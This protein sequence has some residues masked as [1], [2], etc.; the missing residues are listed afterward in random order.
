M[1]PGGGERHQGVPGADGAA[2]QDPL[3][4]HDPHDGPGDVVLPRG[5]EVRHL[6]RLP[7]QER[8]PVGA[9]PAG[10][11]LHHRLHRPRLQLPH[12]HVVQEEEGAGALHQDVVDAVVHQVL[13]HRAVPA[14]Q[15][16]DLQ[17]GPHP[18]RAGHQHGAAARPPAPG[19]AR[20]RSPAPRGCP[21]WPW[22]APAPPPRAWRGAPRRCRRRRPGRR[23]PS[24]TPA[25]AATGSSKD[26][27]LAEVP[28]PLLHLLRG[29]VLEALHR[30]ALARRTTPSPSRRSRRGAGRRPPCARTGPGAP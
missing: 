3:L 22:S 28:H 10:H 1:Q 29:E 16:G 11:P 6:R 5:V 8:A 30:E 4:V 7:A 19:T 27:H 2:V 21:G 12:P 9:A 26:G 25:P 15:E 17:L 18:V 20:R 14:G 23:A 13:P 24:Q